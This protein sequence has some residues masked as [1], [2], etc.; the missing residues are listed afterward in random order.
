MIDIEDPTIWSKTDVF[1]NNERIQF[2]TKFSYII[3]VN[4]I[5]RFELMRVY[6]GENIIVKTKT[7]FHSFLYRIE[8]IHD[9]IA[10]HITSDSYSEEIIGVEEF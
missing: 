8:Q 10:F 7:S 5:S 9:G 3:E 1:L 2:I 4:E 6:T